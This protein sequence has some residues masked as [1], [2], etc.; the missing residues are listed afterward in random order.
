[1]K[2]FPEAS[3]IAFHQTDHHFQDQNVSAVHHVA[4]A[5]MAQSLDHFAQ[6]VQMQQHR[7]MGGHLR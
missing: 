6:Y 4:C 7:L 1:M 5:A 2:L 3:P